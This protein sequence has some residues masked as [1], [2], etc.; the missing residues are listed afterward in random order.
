[1]L[2]RVSMMRDQKMKCYAAQLRVSPGNDEKQN[3]F[4]RDRERTAWTV[5]SPEQLKC[6]KLKW[7]GKKLTEQC[8][9]LF[10]RF[11]FKGC[12]TQQV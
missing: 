4:I 12:F 7:D 2:C 9:S 6:A 11:P 10:L 8:C 5:C 3:G 1:M